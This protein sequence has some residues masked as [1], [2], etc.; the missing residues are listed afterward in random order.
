MKSRLGGWVWVLCCGGILLFVAAA[1][2]PGLDDRNSRQRAN[3]AAA[4][5]ALRTVTELE[6]KYAAAH[7]EKGFAC[8]LPRLRPPEQAQEAEYDP[9]GFLITRTHSGYKFALG[10]CHA[11]ASEVIGHYQAAAVPTV[12]GATGFKAFCTDESGILWYD[13]SGSA[14][15]CLTSRHSLE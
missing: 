2:I 12:P 6:N 3:Q 7:P 8:E 11:D 15:A 5:G 14:T 9:L 1:I 4:V 13:A 10:N